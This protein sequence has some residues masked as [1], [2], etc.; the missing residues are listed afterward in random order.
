L[1]NWSKGSFDDRTIFIKE[2]KEDAAVLDMA[3]IDIAVFAK[4]NAHKNVTKLVGCCLE[5]Q[6][7][8]LVYESTENA[9]LSDRIFAFDYA[10][11]NNIVSLW[12]GKAG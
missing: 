7:P 9:T 1:Y 4:A 8:T 10:K 3:F 11:L 5:T 2:Y 6:I 12:R